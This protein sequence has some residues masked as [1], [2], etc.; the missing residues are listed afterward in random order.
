MKMN[1]RQRAIGTKGAALEA[2]LKSI[3]KCDPAQLPD[4][5][6]QYG[7][8]CAEPDGPL[9]GSESRFIYE[10]LTREEGTPIHFDAKLAKWIR[11]AFSKDDERRYLQWAHVER[12]ADGTVYVL[13]VD[14]IVLHGVIVTGTDFV[15]GHMLRIDAKGN[16]FDVD[17]A[18]L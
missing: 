2:A 4:Y 11:S 13:G 5:L 12:H 7:A 16:V 6:R 8:E 10:A 17:R 9:Y 1:A 14:G 18:A 3:A 15:P